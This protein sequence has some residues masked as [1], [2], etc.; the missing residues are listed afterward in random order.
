MIGGAL[1]G[2]WLLHE[3]L[4]V[5]EIDLARLQERG[6][7]LR[8]L[9]KQLEGA[10]AGHAGIQEEAA[11]ALWS[12]ARALAEQRLAR[13]LDRLTAGTAMRWCAKSTPR[14]RISASDLPARGP[15]STR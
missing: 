1:G 8:A 5:V 6:S 9:A 3:D 11:F 7:N 14:S 12:L 4:V 10:E 13:S 2:L 15:I